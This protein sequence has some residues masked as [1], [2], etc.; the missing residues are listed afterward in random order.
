VIKVDQRVFI[1]RQIHY[2][3]IIWITAVTPPDSATE[4]LTLR[5]GMPKAW[6]KT[7][8][9]SV[10]VARYLIRLVFHQWTK[11]CAAEEFRLLDNRIQ[12]CLLRSPP[13]HLAACSDAS[14]AVLQYRWKKANQQVTMLVKVR[15][16][17]CRNEK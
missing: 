13:C 12:R 15:N 17:A 8:R 9:W 11:R 3:S 10:P 7:R 16:N 1:A 2:Y 5:V 14:T 6:D 4:D